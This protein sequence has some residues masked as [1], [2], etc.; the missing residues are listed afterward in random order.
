[1]RVR[2]ASVYRYLLLGIA[3]FL[4]VYMIYSII[5]YDDG[6]HVPIHR[7]QR[8]L[9]LTVSQDR[10]GSRFGNL[11]PKRILYWTTVFGATVPAT[12]LSDCPGLTDRCVIDTNRHQIESA[13]AVVFHAADLSRFPLPVSRKPNQ[14]FVFNSMETPDNS[15]RFAVPDSFFNWT[16]THLYSSDAIHKYGSFLIPT[17]IA[18]SRGFKVQSYYVQPKR[19]QKTK[20]GIFGLISN[21][22]TTSK[23]ELALLAL[24]K[25]INITIG[26][27]CA[28]DDR[29]KS[30]CPPGVECLDV[31]E[32]YP[33][34]IAIENTVCNDYVTE[35]IWSRISVPSIPIVMRRRVYKNILPPKSFIAMDDYRNPIEMANHLRALEA[36]ATAY[37]EYFD[38]RQKGSW[39]SA[40]WNSPG[41]R[42]GVCRV[43]E[44][45]WKAKSN[46]TE[47]YKSYKNVWKW[48][49]D[50]SQCE[51]DEFVRSWLST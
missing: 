46:E 15:G 4:G 23:R 3:G 22:H 40:P 36:N 10:I 32:Q 34:Y 1:M 47:P 35:K 9:Y 49:D 42:N 14:V 21:C 31:F 12:M 41:Y 7:P 27:K 43:C 39:T 24:Q 5:G 6:S 37:A 11:A 2:P 33:F 44:L 17:Q 48:F 38:W 26:G 20:S 29:L 28:T 8:H 45:L 13:D 16:S 30:I 25:H 19:L 18:E 50:E 51:K